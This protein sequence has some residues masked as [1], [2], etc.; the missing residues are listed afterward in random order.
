MADNKLFRKAALDRL[1]SPEQLHT[2]MRV[3]NAK[4]WLALAGCA[5]IIATAIVWGTLGSVQTK[6]GASGI[7][8]GGGGLSELD[9]EGEG[10]LTSIE[11]K[12]GDLVKKGQ[13]IAR[14]EQPALA[15]QIASL[16]RRLEELGN[17][18][19]A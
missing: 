18:A 15:Q 4:G 1:S 9:A 11:V 5:L 14:I 13:V 3:T 2:L 7:L 8:L 10:D 6:V 19:D 12:A 16:E 17:D